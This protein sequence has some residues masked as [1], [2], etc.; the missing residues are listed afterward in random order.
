M[1]KYFLILAGIIG[2]MLLV[3]SQQNQALAEVLN[4]G[5]TVHCRCHDDGTCQSGY[6]ISFRPSC[7]QDTPEKCHE[8][9]GNCQ[10]P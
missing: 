6:A 1:R 2:F 10:Q 7:G 5:D 9:Q 4:V 8:Y 3:P